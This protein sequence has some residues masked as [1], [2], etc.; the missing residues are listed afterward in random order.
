M[1]SPLPGGQPAAV[2]SA[3]VVVS[4]VAGDVVVVVVSVVVVLVSVVLVDVV[5][6]E[7]E[8]DDDAGGR[9]WCDRLDGALVV[10]EALVIDELDDEVAAELEELAASWVDDVGASGAEEP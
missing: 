2:G 6:V 7:L 4:V 1:T 3:P 10:D 8:L 5:A 9:G